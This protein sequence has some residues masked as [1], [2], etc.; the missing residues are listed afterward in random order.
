MCFVWKQ[1]HKIENQN[2][3]RHNEN[4]DVCLGIY[5]FVKKKIDIS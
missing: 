2:W 5:A 1:Q 4:M 3:W